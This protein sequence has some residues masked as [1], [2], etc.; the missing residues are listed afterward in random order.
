MTLTA[1]ILAD[2]AT[3]PDSLSR[4]VAA[5][6]GERRRSVANRL[7]GLAREGRA[8]GTPGPRGLTIWRLAPD[9]AIDVAAVDRALTEAGVA[10]GTP[11]RTII[12]RI[13]I[14][15]LMAAEEECREVTR[16]RRE[17]AAAQAERER[18]RR[19][20]ER[21]A[22]FIGQGWSPLACP[23]DVEQLAKAIAARHGLTCDDP[24]W[25][26]ATTSSRLLAAEAGREAA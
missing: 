9:A 22:T 3:Y 26:M 5:R 8:V 19:L 18:W 11:E 10:R 20:A 25:V 1:R 4:D 13:R 7:S 15:G 6:L 23:P 16:L 24:A 14:L 12:E 2:L 21:A 17:L